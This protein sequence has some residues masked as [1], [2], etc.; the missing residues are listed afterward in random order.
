MLSRVLAFG[1]VYFPKSAVA[2]ATLQKRFLS[3]TTGGDKKPTKTLRKVDLVKKVA[4]AHDLT[5][6]ETKKILESFLNAISEVSHVVSRFC[7]SRVSESERIAHCATN[8]P[9]R[10]NI[11]SPFLVLELSQ[12][13]SPR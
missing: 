6:D 9:W 4:S 8:S 11:P 12:L 3:A 7:L 2:S 10:Q 5:L 13:T 1:S